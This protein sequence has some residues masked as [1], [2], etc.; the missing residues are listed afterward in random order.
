MEQIFIKRRLRILKR[1][2]SVFKPLINRLPGTQRE[3]EILFNMI[4]IVTL[5]SIYLSPL[6]SIAVSLA[7]KGD[8]IGGV[9]TIILLGVA[10]Y[11]IISY[12]LDLAEWMESMRERKRGTPEEHDKVCE[13][14]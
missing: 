13:R 2:Y 1:L 6:P 14:I 12:I 9:A 4:I 5:S 3:K 10:P 8:I 7:L 11:F